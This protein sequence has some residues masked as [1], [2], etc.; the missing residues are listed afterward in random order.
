MEVYET[1]SSEEKEILTD[2]CKIFS[3]KKK[4]V[5]IVEGETYN[6]KITNINDLKIANAIL[7]ERGNK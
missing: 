7:M 1:L 6:I 5:N 4:K 3:I 2:A